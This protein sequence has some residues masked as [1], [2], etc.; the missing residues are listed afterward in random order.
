MVGPCDLYVMALCCS[1]NLL[2]SFLA[3]YI[4]GEM[5]CLD[6]VTHLISLKGYFV[7]FHSPLI[8]PYLYN[9]LQV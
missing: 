3:Y 1:T 4:L 7:L 2:H 9:I 5:V 8:L 6:K